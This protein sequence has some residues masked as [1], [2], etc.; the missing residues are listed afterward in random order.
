MKTTT[1]KLILKHIST[2]PMTSRELASLIGITRRSITDA[3]KDLRADGSVHISGWTKCGRVTVAQYSTGAGKDADK[4]APF[5]E[6]ERLV[7]RKEARRKQ[8]ETAMEQ[9]ILRKIVMRRGRVA[10]P[11][12][13]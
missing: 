11:W 7:R 2:R 3:L 8:R 1:K 9:D 6:A 4:P 5:A 12:S 10:T 13:I